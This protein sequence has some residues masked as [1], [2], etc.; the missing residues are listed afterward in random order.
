M[1]KISEKTARTFTLE[2]SE[3]DLQFIERGLR[4]D[5]TNEDENV[6]LYDEVSDFMDENDVSLI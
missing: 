1:A 2:V 3:K 6:A 4:R 5:S